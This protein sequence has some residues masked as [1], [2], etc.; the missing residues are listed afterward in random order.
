M[1][2]QVLL[3]QMTRSFFALTVWNYLAPHYPWNEEASQ[4]GRRAN[5]TWEVAEPCHSGFPEP[6]PTRWFKRVLPQQPQKDDLIDRES[7]VR[8]GQPG[9][10]SAP[11]DAAFIRW[12]VQGARVIPDRK[13]NPHT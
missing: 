12:V 1:R 5:R 13:L 10:R 11:A 9:K 2:I 4:R 6:L 3:T 8:D 7:S